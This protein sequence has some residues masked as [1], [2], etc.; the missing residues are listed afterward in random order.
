MRLFSFPWTSRL[1]SDGVSGA[2]AVKDDPTPAN[3]VQHVDI[4]FSEHYDVKP[5][6][7]GI[8]LIISILTYHF[9]HALGNACPL[10]IDLG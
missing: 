9:M 4:T 5:S 8:T 2:Q 3:F 10:P 7:K 1:A 6:N